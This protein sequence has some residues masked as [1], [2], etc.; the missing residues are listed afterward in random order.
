VVLARLEEDA[1]ARA[2]HLDLSA[3]ALAE[4]DAVGDVDGLPE[5]VG[6]P[7]GPRALVIC[8]S[9]SFSVGTAGARRSLFG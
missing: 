1:V 9:I 2:D 3:P 8:M 7:R 5:G 6:V 4:A